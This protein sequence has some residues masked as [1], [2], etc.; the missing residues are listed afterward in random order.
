[1][2]KLYKMF[3]FIMSFVMII[4]VFGEIDYTAFAQTSGEYEYNIIDAS[5]VEITKYNGREANVVIPAEIDGYTVTA[6]ADQAFY[7]NSYMVTVDI[8][9]S[10]K[11]VGTAA[12]S[13]CTKLTQ[14][15]VQ[16]DNPN[17]VSVGGVLYSRDLTTLVQYPAGKADTDYSILKTVVTIAP[18]AFLYCTNLTSINML[19]NLETIGDIAFS[20]CS[21]LNEIILPETL[22]TVGEAAFLYSNGLKDIYYTGTRDEWNT[23]SINPNGN[24]PLNNATFHY[25]YVPVSTEH[26]YKILSV[27]PA[28][29]DSPEIV[30]YKCTD[31][32]EETVIQYNLNLSDFAIKTVSV[33]LASNITMNFKVPK[34]AVADFENIYM[35]FTRNGKTVKISDYRQ[36]GEYIVFAYKNISPQNMN[37]TVTAVLKATHSTVEYSSASLEYSVAKYIYTML[38]KCFGDGNE[39]LRTLLVDLLNYGS[40]AQLYQYY[41]V[42]N[43][44]NADLTDIQKSWASSQSLDLSDFSD[45]AYETIENPMIEWKTTALQLNSSIAIRYKFTAQST[46]NLTFKV[47]CGTS[48][49][50][51]TSDEITDNGDGTYSLLFDG[52]NADKMSKGIYITVYNGSMPVSNTMRYSVESYVKKI[53]SMMPDTAVYRLTDAMMRYGKSAELY[54]AG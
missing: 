3:G 1:M 38:D 5:T 4:G 54:A 43:L 42:D 6:L 2:K 21:A 34:N 41:N 10:I 17:Y 23:V 52:I 7:L 13:A 31:C 27:I 24:N 28:T 16:S 26:N 53:Q 44:V 9:S 11:S 30:E 15:N 40:Q 49:W 46:E 22:K 50:E 33:S 12:L 25:S 36:Q 47:I 14:I 19:S 18:T 51:Y 35:E 48:Q 45:N 20:F 32:G 29:I 39:K 8:P 37:D